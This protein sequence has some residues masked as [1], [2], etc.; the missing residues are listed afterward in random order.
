[1]KIKEIEI[2][3][4]FGIFD[5]KIPIN[6]DEHITIIH[7]PNGFGKT[8][9]LEI[10]NG[11]LNGNYHKTWVIPFSELTIRFDNT[12]IL[13]I[14]KNTPE[15]IKDI[16]IQLGYTFGEPFKFKPF[17]KPKEGLGFPSPTID[18]LTWL[19]EIKKSLS[20]RFIE[21]QRLFKIQ[22]I[23]PKNLIEEYLKPSQPEMLSVVVEYSKKLEASIQEKLTEYASLAQELDRTFPKRLAENNSPN[24]TIDELKTKLLSLELKR[25]ML[26]LAG[27]FDT[28]EKIDMPEIDDQNKNVL[29]VYAED[30]EK[31][32]AIFDDIQAKIELFQEIINKRFLYKT[33]K[34]HKSFGFR[35]L[36]ANGKRLLPDDLSS[37]EQNEL[38]ITY[39][40][41]FEVSPDKDTLV[42]IDEPEISLHIMWQNEFLNDLKKITKLANFDVLIA[43]HSPDI[44]NDYWDLTIALEGPE[45]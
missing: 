29:S 8:V 12:G 7:G 42:L 37:G 19:N 39:E 28:K 16:D 1:M 20:V 14:V 6:T 21:T 11:F 44:I 4:L 31:K 17:A 24:I 5:H 45:I 36:S 26:V 35:F 2:K 9:M 3:G 40:L 27:I 25:L 30:M 22:D 43:T 41:L 18:T 15:D 23:R 33:M 34:T 32:L 10:I 38:V 13:S